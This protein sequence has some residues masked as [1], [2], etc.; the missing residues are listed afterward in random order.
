MVWNEGYVAEVNYTYGFYGELSP[1]KLALAATLK[2]VQSIN[3]NQAFNYCELG[4]GRGYSANLLAAAYPQA[5][6]YAN[7]F[8]PSHVIEAKTLAEA[9]G[10]RNLHF[11]DD[12]FEDFI[13]QE[14][15]N[16]DFIVLHG[17]YSW[18][19]A[20]NRQAIVNFIRKK[21]K[22]GGLVYIS[23]NAL[24]GWAAA[25]PMRSLM[26]RHGQ[27][28]SEPILNRITQ[29][30]NFTGQLL[31]A[32][33]NYFV[34]NPIL[35]NRFE[36]LKDQNP[37]YLAHEYFNQEWNSFYFD[38][39]AKELE[40]AKLNFIGSAHFP[41]HVDTVNLT[42]AVQTKLAQINDPIF[43]EIVRDFCLNTQFRRDIF[44]RGKLS[45]TA[46][47]QVQQL[48]STRFALVTASA[49]IKFEH[50]FPLG[51]VKLQEEIYGPICTTL[52]T[53]ALTLGELQ[54]HPQTQHITLNSLYQALLILIGVGY[55]HPAV[56][57][58]TR[59]QR[60]KSTDA[61]NMAVKTK[62]LYSDEMNYLASPLVGTGVA[63]NRLEQLLL[64][65]K[66]R[67]QSGPEFLW[68][69][70]SSQGKKVVT[71]GK[72]LETEEEN[73]AYLHS[74]A[75]EFERDRLPILTL[76]GIN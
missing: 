73:L 70:L 16:F 29:A 10:T 22:V 68:Q 74:A 1:S 76:L 18:I 12:S 43:R 72:T 55:I 13:N 5:Q 21:L 27:L 50:Q 31:E 6:F 36:R 53:G 61:F 45:L 46:Q 44:G 7:D 71:D 8:N 63:V 14:L 35:K 62:A 34:Q 66:S 56:N 48:Q 32:N 11:F 3:V 41:D 19:S 42:A 52:A 51:E 25:M 38:E 40:V 28:S 2:S 26:L 57:E 69:V 20:K 75:E 4:C 64:L 59:K 39:V 33:A 58:T 54:N 49:N 23:Y 47:E 24:P 9:A 30:L 67:K 60:Q 15:P 65:A 37:N 17:I